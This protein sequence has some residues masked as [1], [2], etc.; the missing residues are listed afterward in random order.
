MQNVSI[1]EFFIIV[2]LR[3]ISLFLLLLSITI[4]HNFSSSLMLGK[5]SLPW[6]WFDEGQ[7]QQKIKKMN[8]KS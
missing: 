5:Y 4:S 1:D 7:Q 8:C 3:I 6:H 2:L